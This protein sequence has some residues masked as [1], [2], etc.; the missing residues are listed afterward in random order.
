MAKSLAFRKRHTSPSGRCSGWLANHLQVGTTF[1]HCVI[2]DEH[3]TTPHGSRSDPQVT[4]V[5]FLMQRMPCT[6][7]CDSEVGERSSGQIVGRHHIRRSEQSFERLQSP[8]SPT[9]AERTEASFGHDLRSDDQTPSGHVRTVPYFQR[10][11]FSERRSKNSGVNT[12]RRR[13]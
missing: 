12:D 5:N 8:P 6:L 1:E 4:R 3:E 11:A 10:R 7:T 13:S 9:S 2:G